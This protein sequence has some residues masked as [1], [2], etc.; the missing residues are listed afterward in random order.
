MSIRDRDIVEVEIMVQVLLVPYLINA[1]SENITSL[2][3]YIA[4][5]TFIL[6]GEILHRMIVQTH[7]NC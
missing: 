1:S 7:S 6:E 4:S 5:K 3:F 2:Q